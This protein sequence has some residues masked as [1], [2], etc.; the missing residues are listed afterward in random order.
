LL[1]PHDGSLNLRH[2]DFYKIPN[3]AFDLLVA[4]LTK[5]K[6][7]FILKVCEELERAIKIGSNGELIFRGEIRLER[8]SIDEITSYPEMSN[9]LSMLARVI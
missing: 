5:H 1:L 3:E 8:T 7:E 2:R 6:K 9:K 4:H